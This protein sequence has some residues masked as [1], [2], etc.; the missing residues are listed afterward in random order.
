MEMVSAPRF[1]QLRQQ[2]KLQLGLVTGLGT[3]AEGGDEQLDVLRECQPTQLAIEHLCTTQRSLE[4]CMAE[5]Q[6]A[7]AT[8]FSHKAGFVQFVFL[9]KKTPKP[10]VTECKITYY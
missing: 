7:T 10:T 4:M 1:P 8:S 6:T 2:T 9:E 3:A 5:E